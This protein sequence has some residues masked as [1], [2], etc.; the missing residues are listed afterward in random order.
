MSAE[1]T[2]AG[3]LT[4]AT[5]KV[6]FQTSVRVSPILNQY[7]VMS[8]GA[9]FIFGEPIEEEQP[10]TVVLNWAAGKPQ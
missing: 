4:T 8:D 5:P 1:I 10:I 6:L 7:A 3:G 9:R 2:A